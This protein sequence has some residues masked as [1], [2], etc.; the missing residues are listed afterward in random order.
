[1]NSN[2]KSPVELASDFYFVENKFLEHHID[3]V[4]K[5]GIRR[6]IAISVAGIKRGDVE[7]IAEHFFSG[8][9]KPICLRIGVAD[10]TFGFSRKP[11]FAEQTRNFVGIVD[12][13]IGKGF[14]VN[15]NHAARID[16]QAD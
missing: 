2:E 5:T 4:A 10:M 11:A 6:H 1:M 16:R 14:F 12:D 9:E 8:R 3:K 7:L 13:C 15:F